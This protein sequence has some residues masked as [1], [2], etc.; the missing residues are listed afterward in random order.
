M[1][2]GL[3]PG[4][5]WICLA[6]RL[7]TQFNMKVIDLKC[8][9]EHCFE[10]WFSSEDDFL[11][12]CN[13]S[14]VQCPVCGDQRISKKPSAPRLV[15]S[16]TR[17]KAA[18][19]AE[20]SPEMTESFGLQSYQREMIALT[21]SIIANTVDMGAEFSNEARKMHYGESPDRAIRGTASIQEARSLIEEGIDVIALPMRIANEGTLH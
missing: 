4:N 6:E 12:Q 15:R 16:V 10:G 1:V 18:D 17:S 9:F 14:L 2:P 8:A 7:E 19:S 3:Q 11:E 13:R 20:K 5:P 21:R